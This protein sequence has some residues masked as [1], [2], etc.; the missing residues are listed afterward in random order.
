M[1]HKGG[2]ELQSDYR[3]LSLVKVCQGATLCFKTSFYCTKKPL[4]IEQ[5]R[6][7][8]T[9]TLKW[10]IFVS[11]TAM[12]TLRLYSGYAKIGTINYVAFTF[13]LC[14]VST[15]LPKFQLWYGIIK[16]SACESEYWIYKSRC[17]EVTQWKLQSKKAKRVKVASL[18]PDLCDFLCE[19]VSFLWQAAASVSF[20]SQLLTL[21]PHHT[22]PDPIF[23][24]NPCV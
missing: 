2:N 16:L 11:S 22:S 18:W 7:L 3:H 5:I 24:T 4:F 23:V 13:H 17:H 15:V 6:K 20:L 1:R 12:S 21:A 14:S 9:I 19:W 8:Q 10:F